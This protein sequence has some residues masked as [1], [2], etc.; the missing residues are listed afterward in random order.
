[1]VKVG[2]LRR[3]A[4]NL[5]VCLTCCIAVNCKGWFGQAVDPVSG[6]EGWLKNQLPRVKLWLLKLSHQWQIDGY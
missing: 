6:T 4:K 5:V 3:R 2:C 1:M